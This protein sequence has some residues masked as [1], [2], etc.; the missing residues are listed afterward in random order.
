MFNPAFHAAI[1]NKPLIDWLTI[2]PIQQQLHWLPVRDGQTE[3]YINIARQCAECLRAI[4]IVYVSMAADIVLNKKVFLWCLS[5]APCACS[6]IE[7]IRGG[8]LLLVV[9][10]QFYRHWQKHRP[11][12]SL[13]CHISDNVLHLT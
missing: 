10:A 9:N 2:T 7:N 13:Y 3:C 4:K 12:T 5:V 1:L 11:L 8:L 6:Q